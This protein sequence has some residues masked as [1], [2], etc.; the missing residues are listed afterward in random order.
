MLDAATCDNAAQEIVDRG[1]ALLDCPTECDPRG[2]LGNLPSFFER[3][4]LDGNT[5]LATRLG[6]DEADVGHKVSTNQDV[7]H[8]GRVKDAKQHLMFS[9]DMVQLLSEQHGTKVYKN[10]DD[11]ALLRAVDKLHQSGLD[12]SRSVLSALDKLLVPKVSLVLAFD[13]THKQL[14]PTATSATRLLQYYVD[15]GKSHLDRDGLTLHWADKGGRLFAICP[16]THK[17]V[18]VSPPEGKVLCFPS[19]KLQIATNGTLP[20]IRH[21]SYCESGVARLAAVTFCQLITDPIVRDQEEA[22]RTGLGKY[23]LVTEKVK[24]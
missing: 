4:K 6:E 23:R 22:V 20:A 5:W 19:V 7:N 13:F 21:G 8:S 2:V 18:D 1:W 16:R 3:R 17:E 12:V 10:S 14:A 11:A 9:E 15:G 24:V